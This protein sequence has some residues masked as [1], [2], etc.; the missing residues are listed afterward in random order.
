[1]KTLKIYFAV[2]FAALSTVTVFAH[3]FEVDGIYYNKNADETSVTVTYRGDSYDAYSDEY[4]GNVVIPSS[5][6]YSGNTYAVTSIGDYAFSR[7]RGLTSITIPNSVTSI[8][9]LAFR[10]CSGLTTIVVESGNTMYDSRNNCNAIVE[11]AT[12]TLMLGCKNTIIPNS[13]TSIGD[14]AFCNCSGLTSITIPNSVTSIGN[15]AFAGCD[16]LTS[17][18]IPNSVTSIGE[19]AFYYCC[20]LTSVTIGNSVTSIGD[21]AFYECYGLTSVIFNAENCNDFSA[22]WTSDNL[23]S[24]TIGDKVQRIPANL[25]RGLSKLTSITIPN[26]VNSIG[27]YAFSGCRGLTSVTIGN[28]VTSIGAYAFYECYGLTSVIFNAENCND[29]SAAWTSDNLTSFTIGD[30]VQRIPAKLCY[31]LSKLTSITIPN[32][33]TSIENSSF[34]GC[35]GLTSVSIGNSVTSI[36]YN[37][38]YGCYGLNLI[39][40]DAVTPP[41]LGSDVFYKVDKS[42]CK[43]VVPDQSISLYKS[44][45]QWRDFLDISDVEMVTVD[46]SGISVENGAIVNRS[47]QQIDV[48]SISGAKAY[49]GNDTE[50]TLPSGIYVVKAGEKVVKVAL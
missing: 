17:I 48:Y 34:W 33:V 2:L 16:G 47:N 19:R 46:E 30:K 23:T 49:S 14:W 39:R 15:K 6:T 22:A 28:S 42:I 21:F 12:N 18:T 5:V 36:G 44:A 31:G 45:K 27:Y 50:I 4:S 9:E 41:S 8:G 13:V 43:L 10:S 3:D 40:C 26:S 7:C 11:S 24:F 38:F 25:C 35:S 29:F 1:M 32:S 37:A 20:G